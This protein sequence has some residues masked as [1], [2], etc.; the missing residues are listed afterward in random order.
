MAWAPGTSL[1]FS[2][3]PFA[4]GSLTGLRAFSV[5]KTTQPFKGLKSLF[6]PKYWTDGVNVAKCLREEELNPH[7]E[8]V[9]TVSHYVVGGVIGHRQ[10][11]YI[12]KTC[13]GMNI[14]CAC[15]FWAYT[16]GSN[17]YYNGSSFCY[18]DGLV[19]GIVKGYGRCVVGPRGF[20]AEKC[21]LVALILP[22]KFKHGVFSQPDID[23]QDKTEQ[24]IRKMYSW[25]PFFATEEAALQQFPLT[26]S[27]VKEEPL[28]PGHLDSL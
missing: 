25:V 15:G 24:D 9:P 10:S 23:Y 26:A 5:S 4:L 27:D 11:C 6:F 1:G 22:A 21:E 12:D 13:D 28:D 16:N 7:C 8:C 18:G 19:A 2:D 14:D 17:D 20:R 3:E